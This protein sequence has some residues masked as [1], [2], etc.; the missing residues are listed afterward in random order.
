MCHWLVWLQITGTLLFKEQLSM[1]L[2]HLT[3]NA[4]N[5]LQKRCL[6]KH[7][8]I[9]ILKFPKRRNERIRVILF[10]SGS[11]LLGCGLCGCT[12]DGTRSKFFPSIRLMCLRACEVIWCLSRKENWQPSRMQWKW[13]LTW[14]YL[15]PAKEKIATAVNSPLAD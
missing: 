13:L 2:T 9:S 1:N 12:W 5:Q 4:T 7:A 3:G 14:L 10:C 8:N 6:K 15:Q 11:A